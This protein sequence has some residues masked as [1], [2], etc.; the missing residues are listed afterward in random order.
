MSPGTLGTLGFQSAALLLLLPYYYFKKNILKKKRNI[1][2][3]ISRGV[4]IWKGV[5]QQG[6]TLGFW[7][8]AAG[9]TRIRSG[10][11]RQQGAA[12]GSRWTH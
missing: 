1:Y 11:F 12:G 2:I 5:R 10:E 3:Y 4:G 8:A 9:H 6:G 7:S